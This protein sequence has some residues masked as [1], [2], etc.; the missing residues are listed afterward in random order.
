[1]KTQKYDAVFQNYD[2]TNDPI[3][4][5]NKEVIVWAR[6]KK[7]EIDQLKRLAEFRKEFWAMYPM[8]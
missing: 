4:A 7:E 2:W 6:D 8:S 5:M 3:S 1:M